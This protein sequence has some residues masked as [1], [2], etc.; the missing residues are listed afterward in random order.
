[1]HHTSHVTHHTSHVSRFHSS[2]NAAHGPPSRPVG[3]KVQVLV[4]EPLQ[5]HAVRDAERG[6]AQRAQV[7]VKGALLV[8]VDGGRRFVQHGVRRFVEV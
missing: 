2:F 6:D 7:V 4:M 1:M 3:V 5:L 8:R